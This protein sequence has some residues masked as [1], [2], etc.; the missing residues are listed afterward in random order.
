MIALSQTPEAFELPPGP[1]VSGNSGT[2]CPE[3][4]H[5]GVHGDMQDS[6]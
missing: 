1:R 6:R 5:K 4:K 2:V 3:E